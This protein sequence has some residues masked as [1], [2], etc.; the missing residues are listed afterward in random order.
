MALTEQRILNQVTVLPNANSINVQWANQILR[1][2]E[3]IQQQYHRKAYGPGQQAEFETE[4]EGASA[5]V[6]LID[7]T[8]PDAAP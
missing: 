2:G 4:V 5:Y 1:D 6:N 3:V 7:W 8:V